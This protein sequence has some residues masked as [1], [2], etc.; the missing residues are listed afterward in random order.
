[1]AHTLRSLPFVLC[2]LVPP[3]LGQEPTE[4]GS[5]KPSAAASRKLTREQVH[6]RLEKV[7]ESIV[8]KVWSDKVDKDPIKQFKYLKKWHAVTSDHYI[9]YTNGPKASC[10]KYAKTLEENYRTIQTALPF[11]DLNHLMVAY[12]FAT[13][14]EYYRFAVEV[15]GY[16]EQAARGTAGHAKGAYYATYYQSPRAA[17]V[18]H[19]AAHQIVHACLKV[20]GVGSWFQEG[21]AV[22][23]ESVAVNKRPDGSAKPDIRRGNYYPVK[24]LIG[25]NTLLSDPNGN[26]RRNY[27]HAGSLVNF[28]INTRLEPVAGKFD[29][30]LAAARRGRGF[31][32]GPEVSEKLIKD[33]YGITVEEFEALWFRHLGVTPKK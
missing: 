1:M 26:G 4:A 29:Q 27:V 25:I 19:E 15:T 14:E 28:M 3:C 11:D 18:Y 6:E 13:P 7:K 33:V 21:T 20:P 5:D 31:A 2:A 30:F 23:F 12:I 22:Y 8:P 16:S 24:D 32:R 17:V 9:I 10:Q